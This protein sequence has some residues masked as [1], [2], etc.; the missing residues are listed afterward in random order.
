MPLHDTEGRC[1][2]FFILFMNPITKGYMRTGKHLL[3]GQKKDNNDKKHTATGRGE[4][5]LDAD[6]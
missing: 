5:G 2:A 6:E 1:G 3:S 4:A